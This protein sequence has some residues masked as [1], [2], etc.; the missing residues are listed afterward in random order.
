MDLRGIPMRQVALC[1]RNRGYVGDSPQRGLRLSGPDY[2]DAGHSRDFW[3]YVEG[4][5]RA[6][7]GNCSLTTARQ[8]H[9]FDHRHPIPGGSVML[10]ACD[11][12][13]NSFG[14]PVS[15]DGWFCAAIYI[16]RAQDTRTMADLVQMM[17]LSE[18]DAQFQ[19]LIKELGI[20]NTREGGPPL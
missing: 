14:R 18:G 1:L 3:L 8:G 11:Y 10:Y 13:R 7:A 20:L 2:D 15:L 12:C 19:K 5:K 9:T 4:A 16:P 17:G 6:F